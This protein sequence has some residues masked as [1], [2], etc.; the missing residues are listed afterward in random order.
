M[1][2]WP[3]LQKIAPSFITSK[4]SACSTSRLPV[5]VM[6]TS[7]IRAASV[8]GMT[9]KPSIAASSALVGSISVTTTFA[10]IPLARDATPL[11]Q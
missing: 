8:I 6:N 7:P 4:C 2:K 11:P 10:P 1:S 9:L 5:T 3:E